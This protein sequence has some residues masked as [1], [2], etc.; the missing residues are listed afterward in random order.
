MQEMIAVATSDDRAGY[1][2]YYD[3]PPNS[4]QPERKVTYVVG[5]PEWNAFIAAGMY[6]GEVDAQNAQY[7]RNSLILT[8][9]L[10]ALIFIVVFAALRPTLASYQ[11]LRML[12]EEV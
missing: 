1:V 10:L 7:I 5:I 12:F 9:S 8:L 3:A 11:T 6:M 2:E 4:N